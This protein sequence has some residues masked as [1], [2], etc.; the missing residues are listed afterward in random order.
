MKQLPFPP[1][2]TLD[3]ISLHHS[4]CEILGAL[5]RK[6]ISL[7]SSLGLECCLPPLSSVS[8]SHNYPYAEAC[9]S[10]LPP[11][12]ASLAPPIKP[13]FSVK[14]PKCRNL[15]LLFVEC[16]QALFLGLTGVKG[17]IFYFWRFQETAEHS[18]IPPIHF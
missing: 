16:G 18:Y 7:C 10:F 15:R 2:T 9:S 13:L 8:F 4:P 3:T 12:S 11:A 17:C 6:S 14:S 1:F 5:F